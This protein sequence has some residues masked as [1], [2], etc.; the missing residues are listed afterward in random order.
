M[1]QQQKESEKQWRC[2][3]GGTSA[4]DLLSRRQK[5]VGRIKENKRQVRVWSDIA[6][7]EFMVCEPSH[8]WLWQLCLRMYCSICPPWRE[9]MVSWVSIW[10]PNSPYISKD[11]VWEGTV[12]WLLEKRAAIQLPSLQWKSRL[13]WIFFFCLRLKKN[14]DEK[15]FLKCLGLFKACKR[16]LLHVL[17]VCKAMGR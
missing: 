6:P 15:R 13:Q 10:P 2:R 9:W 14:G 1:K 8:R 11:F 3:E 5:K 4:N 16:F 7:L 12:C 17:P